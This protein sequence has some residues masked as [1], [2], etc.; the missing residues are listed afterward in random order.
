M[1]TSDA[2]ATLGATREEDRWRRPLSRSRASAGLSLAPCRRRSSHGSGPARSGR[3]AAGRRLSRGRRATARAREAPPRRRA[4]GGRILRRGVAAGARARARRRARGAALGRLAPERLLSG[5]FP[6][7]PGKR[8][9]IRGFQCC[10]SGSARVT[11]C[12]VKR[13]AVLQVRLEPDLLAEVERLARERETTASS[14]GRRA[15]RNLVR[16]DNG[17]PAGVSRVEKNTP[18][19]AASR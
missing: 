9:Q 11:L 18:M 15:L 17:P 3:S 19:T 6:A 12:L 7:Y 13:S 5:D 10:V 14:E 8:L 2:R 16:R 1:R 4:S